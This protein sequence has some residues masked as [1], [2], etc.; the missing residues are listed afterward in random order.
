MLNKN[1]LIY[2]LCFLLIFNTYFLLQIGDSGETNDMLILISFIMVVFIFVF[3]WMSR[4]LL[5]KLEIEPSILTHCL[6]L[7]LIS[8]FVMFLISGGE[9][10]SFGIIYKLHLTNKLIDKDILLFRGQRDFGFSM[11][12][13]ISSLACFVLQII[14]KRGFSILINNLQYDY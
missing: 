8:Q 5:K 13:L 14:F 2:A 9:I 12:F 3:Y 7:Y 10:C 4:L 1:I 11:S 6:I